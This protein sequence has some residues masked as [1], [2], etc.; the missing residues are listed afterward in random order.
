MERVLCAELTHH[1]GHEKG[2]A[3]SG[4][5]RSNGRNGHSAKTV[6]TDDGGIELSIPRDRAGMFE[7]VLVPKGV[8]RS[9]GVGLRSVASGRIGGEVPSRGNRISKSGQ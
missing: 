8:T 6:L 3:A 9:A 7:P 1:L 5:A 4:R 2:A